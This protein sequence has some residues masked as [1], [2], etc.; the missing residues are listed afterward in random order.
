VG[1][2]L[3]DADWTT[4]DCDHV[5]ELG[6]YVS[7]RGEREVEWGRRSREIRS[8]WM[9]LYLRA[10]GP[11]SCRYGNFLCSLFIFYFFYFVFIFYLLQ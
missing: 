9:R 2:V 4:E 8:C 5:A 1:C 3:I 6:N 7:S 11:V 10:T